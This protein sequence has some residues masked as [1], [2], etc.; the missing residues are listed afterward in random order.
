M[1]PGSFRKGTPRDVAKK[2]LRAW[3]GVLPP[4][5]PASLIYLGNDV[6]DL[7]HPRV[8]DPRWKA[9]LEARVLSPEELTV[10]NEGESGDVLRT[11]RFWSFWAAKE[12]GYKILS[13]ALG[14]T[15]VFRH[16]SFVGTLEF[17]PTGE[18][19][20]EVRGEVR[21]GPLQAQIT[22]WASPEYVHL[23]G[24]GSYGGTVLEGRSRTEI[25]VPLEMGLERLPEGLVME[26]LRGHFT[27][28][29]WAG[30]H[31][32]PSAWARILA[33]RRLVG[34]LCLSGSRVEI[35]TSGDSP[36]RTPPTVQVD[37]SPRPE[38]DLSLSHHGRFV[39]W[40]LRPPPA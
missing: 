21:N 33:R 16:R 39:A 24:V 3:S 9:R 15:P 37:V 29:E 23:V 12:T 19:L 35:L 4:M 11:I 38:L 20:L 10:L 14:S 32:I 18:E 31:G 17:H 6:V 26:D 13:K 8:A 28:R 7:G 36:G 30:I 1:L 25:Q 5:P 27:E 2:E 34:H 22:G 40:A